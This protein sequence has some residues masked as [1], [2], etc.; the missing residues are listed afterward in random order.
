MNKPDGL[1]NHLNTST[2]F[3]IFFI[4]IVAVLMLF[5]ANLFAASDPEIERL[6]GDNRFETMYQ[7]A[8]KL[9]PGMVNNVVL[10][11][12][13]GFADTLAGVPFAHQKYAPILLVDKDPQEKSKGIQYP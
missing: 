12:G 10:T 3:R 7:I 8:L 11:S 9:S 13:Y 1:C 2:R 6:F 4:V 5:P